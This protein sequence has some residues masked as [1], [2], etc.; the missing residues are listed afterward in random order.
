MTDDVIAYGNVADEGLGFYS[1]NLEH[2]IG[3]TFVRKLIYFRKWICVLEQAS[4]QLIVSCL[5]R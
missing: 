4:C 5:D 3:Y 2:Q 1:D